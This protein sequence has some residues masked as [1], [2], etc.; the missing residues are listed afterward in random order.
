MSD[1]NQREVAESLFERTQ[2]REEEINH[3][4]NLEAERP[5]SRYQEYAPLESIASGA[6]RKIKDE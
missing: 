6:R 5:R 4:L 2:R 1:K 3:A